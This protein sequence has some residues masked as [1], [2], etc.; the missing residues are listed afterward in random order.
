MYI[1]GNLGAALDDYIVGIDEVDIGNQLRIQ[2]MN[3]FNNP[4]NYKL[5]K[6]SEAYGQSYG[7]SKADGKGWKFYPVASAPGMAGPESLRAEISGEYGNYYRVPNDISIQQW[8]NKGSFSRLTQAEI[9]RRVTLEVDR[10]VLA[11]LKGKQ[12][13]WIAANLQ[14]ATN[15]VVANV[16]AAI[17]KAGSWFKSW[18]LS[19]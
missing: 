7:R 4:D 11:Y 1:N 6:D 19:V 3:H 8:I 12:L 16:K 5:S 13:S 14:S 17:N 18:G 2:V 10:E 9:N 15:A